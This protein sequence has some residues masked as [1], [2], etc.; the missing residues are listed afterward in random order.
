[1][2]AGLAGVLA[3]VAFVVAA[4]APA[5]A[6]TS[7]VDSAGATDAVPEA[8]ADLDPRAGGGSAVGLPPLPLKVSGRFIVDAGGR[9]V[10]LAGVNWAGGHL[11]KEVPD[12]LDRAR[13][14][15]LAAAV[16]RHGMNSVRLTFS[17]EM[18]EQDPVVAA[19]HVA[20]NPELAGLRAMDVLDAV[21][22]ALAAEGVMVILNN[23]TSD[24]IWCCSDTDENGL[25]YNGR[26]PEE[27]WIADWRSVAARYRDRPN[28]VGVDLRNEPRVLAQ[29]GDALGAAFDWPSAAERCAAEVLS[30]NPDLLVFVEGVGYARLL[31]G[32]R[33]RPVELALPGRL[34]YSA[35]DYPWFHGEGVAYSGLAT[36]L[37][38]WWGFL[39][40]GSGP[41][42]APVWVGEF[43]AGGV[44][45]WLPLFLWYLAE[46]DADWCWWRA[47]A[48]EDGFNLI[49]AATLEP[50]HPEVMGALR[51]LAAP[52]TGPAGP[53]APGR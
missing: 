18:V 25:W 27:A 29:W 7:E 52:R 8:P 22:D 41:V 33:D 23:H 32:V 9:R 39:L 47:F 14:S 26:Y 6:P 4:C 53:F 24:S 38:A 15:D 3:T 28:V 10:K 17:N 50:R 44:E 11:D 30:V 37:D 49:D 51:S 16:R 21:V 2:N 45:P 5:G 46:T 48:D 36:E 34:A 40:D 35:H 19:E 1:M 20:A 31:A 12:G 42:I 43:G 13:A